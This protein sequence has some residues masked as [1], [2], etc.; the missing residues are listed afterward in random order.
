LNQGDG[1]A[2]GGFGGHVTNHHAPGAA[3]EAAVGDQAHALAQTRTDERTGGRQHLGHAGPALGAQV[4]QH[5]HVAGLDPAVQDGLERRLLVIEDAGRAGELNGDVFRGG[6]EDGSRTSASDAIEDL[7]GI[8]GDAAEDPGGVVGFVPHEDSAGLFPSIR[9]E[10]EAGQGAHE[11]TGGRAQE[12][13]ARA[14]S[15][16]DRRTG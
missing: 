15:R 12:K 10:M 9:R 5:H 7:Q 14:R 8:A 6:G 2:H 1:A 16:K 11:R 3:R 13:K 4:A